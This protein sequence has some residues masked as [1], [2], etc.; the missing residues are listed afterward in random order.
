MTPKSNP[1]PNPK[2]IRKVILLHELSKLFKL[3]ARDNIKESLRLIEISKILKIRA[4]KVN[5]Y[6]R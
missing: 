3:E 5:V 1:K 2:L 4:Q 6:G